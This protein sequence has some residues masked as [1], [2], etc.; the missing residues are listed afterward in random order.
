[1]FRI[2]VAGLIAITA[3]GFAANAMAQ[4]SQSEE[5]LPPLSEQHLELARQV[6]I[7][8]KTG[9][10]F[11]NILPTVAEQA[12]STFV[13]SNPQIQLGVIDAVDRVALELVPM[14]KELDD[15]LIRVWA[16]AFTE[17]ELKNLLQFFESPAGQKFS[18]NYPK[19]ISTQLA[20]A[21]SWTLKL[22]QVLARRTKRELEKMVLQ[23][24]QNLRG[25]TTESTG[26]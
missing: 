12:K 2:F 17:E 19:V 9:R 4:S 23:D 5:A 3:V 7:A 10:S 13:R 26:Q 15:G 21:E 11:D 25:S 20:L 6:F 16:R 22:S 8:S 14:R 1:M 18:D 24:A